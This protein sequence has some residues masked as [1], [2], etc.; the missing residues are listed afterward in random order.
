MAAG[1]IGE[2]TNMLRAVTR[3]EETDGLARSVTEE[4]LR[5]IPGV[6]AS[7]NEVDLATGRA[8]ARI[9]PEPRP[10]WWARYQPVFEAH[11][12]ENPLLQRLQRDGRLDASTWCEV[13]P[14][15]RFRSTELFRSFYQ[16]LG[17]EE[18]LV[19][20]FTDVD[21]TL[22]GV[23]VNRATRHFTDRERQLLDGSREIAAVARRLVALD[24]ERRALR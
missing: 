1:G 13:D 11:M 8:F 3:I 4:L 5:L 20:G 14:D 22:I 16:P 17:I 15:L 6:S 10:D 12:G 2:L 9:V 21:G 19:S 24:T 23:A 7:Y 18:Q